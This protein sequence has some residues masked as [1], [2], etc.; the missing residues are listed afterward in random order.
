MRFSRV[1]AFLRRRIAR[2][3][4]ISLS[5]FFFFVT[6][7][8]NEFFFRATGKMQDRK[9]F[10]LTDFV[11]LIHDTCMVFGG[12]NG[13]ANPLCRFCCLLKRQN[14]AAAMIIGSNFA[15]T[16]SCENAKTFLSPLTSR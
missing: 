7:T 12:I 4:S 15:N 9:R 11:L 13:F 10:K 1:P 8:K 6:A 3:R 14:A 5:L 2:V 16:P